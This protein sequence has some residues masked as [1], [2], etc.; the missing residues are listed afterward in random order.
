M[1]KEKRRMTEGNDKIE[2]EKSGKKEVRMKSYKEDKEKQKKGKWGHKMEGKFMESH[3]IRRE[4]ETYLFIYC[5]TMK[6]KIDL[7]GI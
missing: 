3:I 6:S 4:S 5:K 1:K 7:G 2:K